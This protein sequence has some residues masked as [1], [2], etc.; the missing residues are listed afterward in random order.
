MISARS[1]WISL[2]TLS[3]LVLAG[4]S[5]LENVDYEVVLLAF[6]CED[7]L[8][9]H[10]VLLG[11]L[12]LDVGHLIL[13]DINSKFGHKAF[14]VPQGFSGSR[15]SEENLSNSGFARLRTLAVSYDLKR[16]L[17]KNFSFVKGLRIGVTGENLFVLTDYSGNDP[18]VFSAY[19]TLSGL[20]VDYG[21]YP[22]PATIT[23]NLRITF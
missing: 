17:L 22:K 13:V 7:V 6:L 11:D 12:V 3:C 15:G 5:I 4:F 2:A 1:F 19:G 10:D 20:G 16:S 23:G 18:E 8:P 14:L 21:S 9:V